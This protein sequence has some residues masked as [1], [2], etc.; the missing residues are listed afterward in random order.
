[1]AVFADRIA[2]ATAGEDARLNIEA[3]KSAVQD[4]V[5][6]TDPRVEITRTEYFNHTYAPDLVLNWAA[7]KSRRYLYIRTDSDPDRLAQDANILADKR[8]VLFSLPRM[9]DRDRQRDRLHSLTSEAD[10]LVTDVAALEAVIERRSAHPVVQLA[11]AALLQGGHGVVDTTQGIEIADKFSSGFV[12]ARSAE[13]D[14][15]AAAAGV[16]EEYFGASSAHRLS[17]F[18]NAIWVGSGGSASEF[19]GPIHSHADLPD[20]SFRFLLELDEFDDPEFWRRVGRKLTIERIVRLAQSSD[21]RNFQYLVQSNLDVLT[22]RWCAID[23]VQP[24]LFDEPKHFR[25][26]VERGNLA[27]SGR[28]F[29]AYVSANV[30]DL[31]LPRNEGR[32][33]TGLA[34]TRRTERVGRPV[35]SVSLGASSYNVVYETQTADAT[36]DEPLQK[37]IATL[38]RA[39]KVEKATVLLP[40]RRVLQCDFVARTATGRGSSVFPVAELISNALMLLEDLNAR[41]RADLEDRLGADNL[42]PAE[43][44]LFQLGDDLAEDQPMLDFDGDGG[45]TN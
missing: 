40:S 32:R 15:T 26:I 23:D 10:V 29:M 34:L 7:D 43:P 5:R 4:E 36:H 13:T 2:I 11:S 12:A 39:A 17:Q 33:I 22:A 42:L 9:L 31:A 38:G 18:L 6:A 14:G 16:I 21:S 20:A 37:I 44:A 1:M 28:R 19:P 3:I 35:E 41:E 8:P 30:G 24:T 25:W 27:L 45:D